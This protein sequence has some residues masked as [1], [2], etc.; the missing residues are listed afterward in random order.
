MLKQ[1][2]NNRKNGV[3]IDKEFIQ[4]LENQQYLTSP[5]LIFFQK[6]FYKYF[7]NKRKI[8]QVDCYFFPE[9][10]PKLTNQLPSDLIDLQKINKIKQQIEDRK[11]NQSNFIS[12]SIIQ[13]NNQFTQYSK[14]QVQVTEKQKKNFLFEII[15]ISQS[16]NVDQGIYKISQLENLL[17]VQTL[18]NDYQ[19]G[20]S[21]SNY[22]Y[23]YFPINLGNYHW[24]SVLVYF[25][26][27]I[28]IY[29]DSLNGYNADIIAGIEKIIKYK[30][31]KNIDWKI[32]KNTPRQIGS[33]DCGVFALYALFFLYTRGELI[34]SDSYSQT[35]ISKVRQNFA[36]LAIAELKHNLKDDNVINIVNQQ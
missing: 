15:N 28:I 8:F 17:S 16:K 27:G 34:K 10:M 6:V 29:Q 5:H 25:K 32:Q 19:K 33:S 2:D 1:I 3:T 30:C 23:A 36:T 7:S 22:D 21:I 26:E 20:N 35:F 9:F 4:I 14:Q 11:T 31:S 13:K 24:I 12:N 18:N